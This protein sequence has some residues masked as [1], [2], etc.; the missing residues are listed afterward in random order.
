M[1]K[2]IAKFVLAATV[3]ATAVSMASP[4]F[5]AKAK[6]KAASCV[7]L[8]WCAA[9]CSGNV[10]ATG[11]WCGADGKWHQGITGCVEPFCTPKC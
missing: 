8:S 10:C 5:A 6:K 2:S 7:P 11:M 4:S 3:A 1:L 9:K